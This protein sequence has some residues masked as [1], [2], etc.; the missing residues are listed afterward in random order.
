MRDAIMQKI[1]TFDT[2]NNSDHT[3]TTTHSKVFINKCFNSAL[4]YQYL[5]KL[6]LLIPIAPKLKCIQARIKLQRWYNRI[7]IISSCLWKKINVSFFCTE[8]SFTRYSC[9]IYLDWNEID[10]F[11][12]RFVLGSTRICLKGLPYIKKQTLF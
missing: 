9:E 1:R 7:K 10:L 8:Y 11:F 6:I 4:T 12:H 3:H 5:P 2:N